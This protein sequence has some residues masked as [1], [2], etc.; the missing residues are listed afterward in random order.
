M[1]KKTGP[2]LASNLEQHMSDDK[3]DSM[4]GGR[5]DKIQKTD[6]GTDVTLNQGAT[7]KTKS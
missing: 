3:L 5:A 6:E 2:E 1:K 4:K 7:V